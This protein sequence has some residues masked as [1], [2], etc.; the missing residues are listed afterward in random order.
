[1]L[2]GKH[3]MSLLRKAYP[4]STPRGVGSSHVGH[5]SCGGALGVIA[6]FSLRISGIERCTYE[7]LGENSWYKISLQE[8]SYYC[9]FDDE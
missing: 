6:V 4:Q 8:C 9:C 3:G 5:R 7:S 1:M 2:F